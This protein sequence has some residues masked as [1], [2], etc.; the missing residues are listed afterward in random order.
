MIRFAMVFSF[1]AAACG[2]SKSE[3]VKSAPEAKAEHES[4]P[5]ELAKFHDTLAPRW[6]A[7]K[8]PER[9]KSTCDALP[10]FKAG[11]TTI[12]SSS[13]PK[14]ADSQAWTDGA[15]KLAAA[16]EELETECK[17]NDAAKFEAAFE[18]VHVS[19]HGL[20]EASGGEHEGEH[21]PHDHAM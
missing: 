5:P 6:H 8:G 3:P 18:Q 11:A 20:L 1:V 4:M 19:F 14:G 10:D 21:E 13:P 7:A 17:A 9:M 12:A 16:L 2:G 15:G